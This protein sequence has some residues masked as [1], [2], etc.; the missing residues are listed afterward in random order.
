MELS[1]ACKLTWKIKKNKAIIRAFVF[2]MDKNQWF[3]YKMRFRD[4]V[5]GL[6]KFKTNI[7]GIPAANLKWFPFLIPS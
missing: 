1:L 7:V 6:I 5:T 3:C 4:H 2:L